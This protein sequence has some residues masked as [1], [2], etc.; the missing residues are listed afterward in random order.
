MTLYAIC[1][2]PFCVFM[3]LIEDNLV[4]V[5]DFYIKPCPSNAEVI[6]RGIMM[7][8]GDKMIT[9]PTG[10]MCFDKVLMDKDKRTGREK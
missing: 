10:L 4:N 5:S 2:C 9:K 6:A 3:Y 1:E 7:M 8:K